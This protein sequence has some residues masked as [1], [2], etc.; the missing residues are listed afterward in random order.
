MVNKDLPIRRPKGDPSVH[1]IELSLH[2]NRARECINFSTASSE[3]SE[4]SVI[5]RCPYYGGVH[6]KGEVSCILIFAD[7]ILI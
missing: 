1:I 3:L 4:L 2:I 5:E 6:T 7:K